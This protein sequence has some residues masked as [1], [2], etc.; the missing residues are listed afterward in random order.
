MNV[1]NPKNA[2]DSL[3]NSFGW[4]NTIFTSYCE[5]SFC[6]LLSTKV[7]KPARITQMV[8]VRYYSWTDSISCMILTCCKC[9]MY[10]I[11]SASW[12]WG[13][14]PLSCN[15]TR[16]EQESKLEEVDEC[17]FASCFCYDFAYVVVGF[18]YFMAFARTFYVCF[19]QDPEG[20]RLYWAYHLHQLCWSEE[21]AKTSQ[22]SYLR[23]YSRLQKKTPSK[24][25]YWEFNE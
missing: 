6:E 17:I 16:D 22:N 21:K 9:L 14:Y 3:T 8:W 20:E 18:W 15:L 7:W 4:T 1:L 24:E 12:T 23:I 13:S 2:W 10:F 25:G 19:H 11:E 5:W